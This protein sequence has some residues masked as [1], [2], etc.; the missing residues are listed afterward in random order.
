MSTQARPAPVPRVTAAAFREM[1]RSGTPIVMLTAYDFHSAR[2]VEAAGVDA[3]LVGDSLGM[4]VLGESSTL[5]VTMD[6]M[7]RATRAVSRATGHALVIADMPFMSYQADYAE[8]M[9]NAGRFLAQAGAHAVKLEGATADTLA[10]VSGLAGAGIPVMGHIGL[11]PQSVNTL[12]G[13]RTQGKDAA[14]AAALVLDALSLQDAGAFAVVLECVPAELAEKISGMLDIPTIG[15][16]AG[17]GCDG[18]VQVFHDILGLGDFLPRHAKRY[19]NLA[20]E[21]GRAVSAYAGD[22]RGRTFPGE[23]QSTHSAAG[24]MDEVD[25]R[26]AEWFADDDADGPVYL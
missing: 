20:E 16:G 22:V 17:V 15:I 1:K 5:P 23:E 26:L 2:L 6:D 4:T 19:A 24:V 18:Q 10:L 8:G 13:Y 21:I 3:I 25:A 14:G 11:T 7:L 9:R 12:G